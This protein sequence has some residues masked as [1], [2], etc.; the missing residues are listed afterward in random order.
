MTFEQA[1]DFLENNNPCPSISDYPRISMV[2]EYF[3]AVA[4]LFLEPSD[5]HYQRKLLYRVWQSLWAHVR[6]LLDA[7]IFGAQ[8]GD[9]GYPNELV[10]GVDL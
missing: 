10:E 2:E 7:W 6:A 4:Q 1:V 5:Q 9:S 3:Y 8:P